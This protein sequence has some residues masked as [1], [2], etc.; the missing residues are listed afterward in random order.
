MQG[1]EEGLTV[2]R[3]LKGDAVVAELEAL[4]MV[5]QE[6]GLNSRC[7]PGERLV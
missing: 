1:W 4:Q 7:D 2:G 5:R 3:R 6:R